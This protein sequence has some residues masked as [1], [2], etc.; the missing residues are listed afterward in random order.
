MQ[1]RSH[2]CATSPRGSLRFPGNPGQ[3]EPSEDAKSLRRKGLATCASTSFVSPASP[4]PVQ[5]KEWNKIA[6]KISTKNGQRSSPEYPRFQHQPFER[7][8]QLELGL[9]E[10]GLPTATLRGAE[11]KNKGLWRRN[12]VEGQL[13]KPETSTQCCGQKNRNSGKKNPIDPDLKSAEGQKL[14]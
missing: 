4:V 7:H 8:S 13:S 5:W 14:M 1:H 9:F 2:I 3:S 6:I 12:V 11:A 10:L